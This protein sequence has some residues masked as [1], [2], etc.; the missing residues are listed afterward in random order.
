MRSLERLNARVTVM[1]ATAVVSLGLAIIAVAF[2]VARLPGRRFRDR[3]WLRRPGP[4]PE[5]ARRLQRRPAADRAPQRAQRRLLGR[6]RRGPDPGRGV[7]GGALLTSVPRRGGRVARPA[8]RRGGHRRPA[9]RVAEGLAP[10]FG[11]PGLDLH[12]R[13][14]ALRRRSRTEPAAG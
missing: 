12:R 10:A 11:K 14:R 13:L 5:P 8:R 6:R 9:S 2:V 7:R 3:F 1:V 4:R